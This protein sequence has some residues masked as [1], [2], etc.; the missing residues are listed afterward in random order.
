[1]K[2]WDSV[3]TS[4]C[5]CQFDV[6]I[7]F[8]KSIQFNNLILK[9]LPSYIKAVIINHNVSGIVLVGDGEGGEFGG[10]SF[11]C[12]LEATFRG[13]KKKLKSQRP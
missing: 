5:H 13:Q 4:N 3:Y 2:I 12:P 9:L 11:R 10:G 8:K 7:F 1:M 6:N